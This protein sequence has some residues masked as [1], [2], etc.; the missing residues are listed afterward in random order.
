M[1]NVI[2][3]VSIYAFLAMLWIVLSD[4]LISLLAKDFFTLSW[5]STAKGVF[6]VLATSLILYFLIRKEIALKSQ[7]IK[8]LETNLA[9]K[10]DLIK[11]LHHR[12]KNNLQV[13]IGILEL[14]TRRFGFSEKAKDRIK[15]KLF[16]LSAVHDIIYNT[17]NF[18]SIV[19]IDVLKSYF[20]TL[21]LCSDELSF[22]VDERITY[23]VEEM[24]TIVLSINEL[25]ETMKD[26]L[27]S[28]LCRISAREADTIDISFLHKPE[29][30][31]SVDLSIITILLISA[32]R[33]IRQ[34]EDD[35][36]YTFRIE[37]VKAAC[38]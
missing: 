16:S 22:A 2:K 26:H 29:T 33:I 6:Y 27:Q 28:V 23:P 1:K 9:V 31:V 24:V 13:I 38:M 36:A 37:R 19:L 15:N 20:R 18:E 7:M 11:E 34:T 32:D 8:K 3:I 25:I 14:E 17:E 12:V 35:D 5:F 10:T 21:I 30:A 4:R